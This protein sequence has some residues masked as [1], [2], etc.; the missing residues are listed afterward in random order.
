MDLNHRIGASGIQRK[1]SG[2]HRGVGFGN[3][4][5]G[6]GVLFQREEIVGIAEVVLAEDFPGAVGIGESKSI[7]TLILGVFT[8]STPELVES[9]PNSRRSTRERA[10]LMPRK[11]VPK[12]RPGVAVSKLLV[13]PL[14]AVALRAQPMNQLV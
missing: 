6:H 11:C 5:E 8:S 14:A 4:D 9:M 7:V 10:L 1:F 2:N 13:P 3:K 12:T